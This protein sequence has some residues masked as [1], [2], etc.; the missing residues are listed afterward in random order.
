[1]ATEGSTADS[2][3]GKTTVQSANKMSSSEMAKE[4]DKQLRKSLSLQDLFFMSMGAIIGSG[5]LLGVDKGAYL[6]GP[7]AVVGWVVGG[8][9]ILFIALVY[10]EISG[11]IPRSGS[12]VRYPHLSHGGYTGFILGW[13]Y[14]LS[15]VTVPTIEAEAV[16]T[17]ASSYFPSWV[18]PSGILSA[19]GVA[20]ALGMLVIFFFLNYAGIKFL[21]RFNT[22][23]TWWKFIIPTL[24]FIFLFFAFRGSNYS[25]YQ[26]FTPLGVPAMF[27]AIPTFTF[28]YLGFRQALEYGGEAK[29][30]QRDVPRAT[31]YSIITATLLYALLQIAFI[32]AINWSAGGYVAGDWASLN[33]GVYHTAPFYYAL[34]ET[35]I[36]ALGAFAVLL[37]IDA[38]VSP[39]GTGWIY[40][41]TGAR[42][43]YGLSADG[44]FPKAFLRLSQRTKIPIFSLIAAIVVGALFLAPFPS[45]YLLVDFIVGTSV[46]TYVLGPLAIHIFRKHAPD[47][48]RPFRLPWAWLWAPLGFVGGTLIIYWSGYPYLY[49]VWTAVFLGLPI[50]YFLYAPREMGLKTGTSAA[51]GIV[52]AIAV[53]L[54]SIYGYINTYVYD[55]LNGISIPVSDSTLT[56]NFLI[57]FALLALAMYIPMAITHRLVKKEAK[58][59]MGASY[60]VVT[61]AFFSY[62]ISFFGAF[63]PLSS[64]PLKFPYDNFVIIAGSLGIYGWGVLSGYKT[65]AIDDLEEVKR[66]KEATAEKP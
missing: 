34:K 63:G 26:G 37:L 38:W 54:I 4:S 12:I 42:T 66:S 51:I 6:A 36:P 53:A 56:T 33:T 23:V 21:G 17:Y 48:H 13:A 49:Y 57:Y 40:A 35:G 62:I 25:A 64:I 55:A 43:F 59:M 16:I 7:S 50:F 52:Q 9:I 61:L 44:Y 45:W 28:A 5:W 19:Q 32:G 8:I 60:W 15:A 65:E 27:L 14:L 10:A 39:S 58:L 2:N 29:N 11:A 20:V 31:I 24:T 18:T 3:V 41:G 1:M 30:P 46:F 22:I 47:M